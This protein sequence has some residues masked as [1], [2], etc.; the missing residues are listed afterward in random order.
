MI[1]Y[2]EFGFSF[3]NEDINTYQNKDPATGEL[4]SS[5]D[6]VAEFV[7]SLKDV[8]PT[9]IEESVAWFRENNL[10]LPRQFQE[11]ILDDLK[12][13]K[14]DYIKNSK[15][16]AQDIGVLYNGY[17]YQMDADGKANILGIRI[18]IQDGSYTEFPIIFKTYEN[19]YVELSKDQYIDMSNKALD[20]VYKCLEQKDYLMKM[21]EESKTVED[22]D[23]IK[24]EFE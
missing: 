14:I 17:H 11:Y 20:F 7:I 9:I 5:M 24:W 16:K 12:K 4:F 15:Q 8:Y 21:V 3:K 13:E 18:A 1:S 10:E 23:K 19:V 6:Q 2:F 22:L